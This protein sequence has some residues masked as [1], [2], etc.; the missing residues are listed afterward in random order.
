MKLT[1]L[2]E[3]T[4]IGV[5]ALALAG[6]APARDTAP[7]K[8]TTGEE[9]AAQEQEKQ[10]QEA[11]RQMRE[12]ERQMREAERQM[13]DAQRK[14]E[15]AARRVAR[16][17]VANRDV[18]REL[19]R[20]VFFGK[21]ARLGVVLNTEP[22]PKLDAIGARIEAVTP[23]GPAD[24]AG[25]KAGDTIT[26]FDGER[27][28]PTRVDPD[29]E[30]S[31]PAE[32]LKDL[33][34]DLEDGQKVQIEYRRGNETKTTTLTAR[35]LDVEGLRMLAEIPE[36]I[37]IAPLPPLPPEAPEQGLWEI[38]V[39]RNSWDDM[40]MVPLNPELG[41]YFGT[42]KGLLVVKAP[43]NSSYKLK[44]GDVI[45]KIGAREP[46]TPSQAYRILRSY[47]A[48][49]KLTFE[50]MRDKRPMTLTVEVPKTSGGALDWS[51]DIDVRGAPDVVR[52]IEVKR[53]K[54]M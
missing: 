39:H 3:T 19:R 33:A 18:E 29:E 36:P 17:A 44:S 40:E 49:E 38:R 26:K 23:G 31:A 47:A 4:V 2:L 41:T 54:T 21:R 27:L 16:S 7:Q 30:E 9:K 13:R 8:P 53:T 20:Y 5:L 15:D 6:P 11:E 1:A 14:L 50:I 51:K 43:E 24:E 28:A 25:L 52:E 46:E 10:E 32:K 42:S 48:G 34:E 35:R 37:A 12:A 45:L 22:D